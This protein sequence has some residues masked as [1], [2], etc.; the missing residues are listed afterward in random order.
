MTFSDRCFSF[1]AAFVILALSGVPPAH[2]VPL[3]ITSL[4]ITPS[5]NPVTS[6]QSSTVVSL[7]A[8]VTIAGAPATSGQ[9]IFCD[10]DAVACTDVHILGG[11]QILSSGT[12]TLPYIPRVGLHHYKTV[13][14][15][16]GSAYPS[17]PSRSL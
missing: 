15:I 1:W 16:S 6:V 7:T 3:T 12:A 11:A 8:T 4:S 13:A 10:A 2:A 5:G 9:I 14:T 17:S